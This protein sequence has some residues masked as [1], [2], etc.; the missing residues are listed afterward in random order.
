MRSDTQAATIAPGKQIPLCV[1]EIRGNEWRYIKEC[2]DS[3][4]VSYVGPFVGRFEKEFAE[5]LGISH[6]V[7]TV[8]GTAALHIA[9]LIAGVE[10][11]NEVLVSTLSFIAPANAIRYAGAWPVFIDAEP[12]YW[13]MDVAKA[14]DFLHRGCEWRDGTLRNRS[15]GRPVRAIVPVHILGH[16]VDL[17]PLMEAARKY[18]L[19]VIE[20]ATESLGAKYKGK[21]VGSIGDISCFSFNG[22]KLLTTG[23]GGM[24]AT[25]NGA[26]AESAKYLTT[27]AKDDPIEYVHGTIGYNYRLTNVQAAVGCAQLE[28]LDEYVAAKRRIASIYLQ[29]L[30]TLPGVTPM[31]EADWA[32]SVF[33]MYTMSIDEAKC[34]VDSRSL[35]QLLAADGIQ[36]RP[37]WQPLHRSKPH[38]QSQAWHCHVADDLNRAAL[39]LPCS[40]G[41]TEDQQARVLHSVTT[42]MRRDTLHLSCDLP[43]TA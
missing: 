5:G 26:W 20:D 40:V 41:L 2:L 33:W 32:E 15:T 42:R 28:R 14:T 9:L 29:G 3:N 17:D 34:G 31:P 10:P 19:V 35:L 6:A 13:Q 37:L 18:E 23:G 12:R 36:T 30:K 8:S 7:A 4:F 21:A 25:N 16:P 1:P 24:I 43:V 39:S 22:N 38:R 11:D 27:Q